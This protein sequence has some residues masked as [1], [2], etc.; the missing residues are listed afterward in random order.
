MSLVPIFAPVATAGVAEV[1]SVSEAGD[2]TDLTAYTFSSMALGAAASDRKIV[3]V[4]GAVGT[5]GGA[6]TVSSMTVGGVTAD[7]VIALGNTGD[8]N[9][10]CAMLQADVPTGT[11]GDVVVTWS[12]TVQGCAAVVHRV[13]GAGT[14]DSSPSDTDSNSHATDDAV[15][16]NALTQPA[17]GVAIMGAFA[18]DSTSCA[19]TNATEGN[20]QVGQSTHTTSDASI[21]GASESTPTITATMSGAGPVRVTVVG[22]AWAAA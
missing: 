4:V 11:T 6:L 8:T 17:D 14:G 22:A 21:S 16:I 1:S 12:K 10:H 2:A 3:V 15:A 20:D 9:Y 5:V 7:P 19:W 18:S 13:V